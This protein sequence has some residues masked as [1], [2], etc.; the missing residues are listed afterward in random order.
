[1]TNEQRAEQL[2]KLYGFDF[3]KINK[4]DIINLIEKE[5]SDFQP[6]SSEYI[7]I[8]CGYLFCIG[9]ESDAELIGKAKH[10]I[11]FD[12]ECMIDGEWIDSL[13]GTE[14]E[15]TRPRCEIIES[16]VDCCKNFEADDDWW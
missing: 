16:F 5:I 6:G 2:I 13:K 15:Y 12:V 8:L 3:E 4:A 10:N 1:M 11:N 9:D 14:N 7:R